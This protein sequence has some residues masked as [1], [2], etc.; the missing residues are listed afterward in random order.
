[1]LKTYTGVYLAL[2]ILT[3]TTVAASL[4]H[5][6]REGAVLLAL[7]IASVKA[8]L[9]G[10]YFMHLNTARAGIWIILLVGLL[11]VIILAI[12]IFPDMAMQFQ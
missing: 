12:G 10:W 3:A 7:F 1:M 4:L 8:A 2:L 11:S 5:L 9:I 6:S